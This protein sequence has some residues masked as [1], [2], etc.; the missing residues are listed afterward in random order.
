MKICIV[1]AG[2]V[3]GLTGAWLAR[4]GH[5]VSLVA[6]GAHLESIRANGLTLAEEGRRESFRLPVSEEPADF[7]VQD[8]VFV[9]LKTYSIAAMLPRLNTLVGP[10]TTVVPA[11][12]GLP[13]WYFYREGGRFDGRPIDC[14]DPGG[15]MLA[16]LDPARI[17]GCVV[18]AAA[19][20]SD[21]G[22]V[23]HT[24]GKLFVLGEPDRSRSAR[25]ERLAAA[26]N[27][28]GFEVKIAGDIRVEVWTKLV[29]NLSYN[30]IA[31]LTLARMNDINGS[32][33]LL[34]VIRVLMQEAMRV[35][36]AYG[37]RVPVTIEER[38]GISRRLAGAKISMHQDIEK[39]RPLETEAIVGAVAELARKAGIATPMID[40]V[41]ALIAERARHLDG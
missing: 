22:V 20:V 15:A 12:N 19:Q 37:A 35:A 25:A 4:A 14:L 1:G 17:L 9:C 31:A 11:I 41:Y 29:G 38:I 5:E 28:A 10:G 3:G 32:E 13:W 2:S 16:A 39:R 36:E 21:P 27:E 7:G 18:H 30:P 34:R 6:R 26:M 8:A 33:A 40:A 23:T 24:A